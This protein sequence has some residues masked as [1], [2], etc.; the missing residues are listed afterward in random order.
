MFSRQVFFKFSNREGE[1][2]V[3]R[4]RQVEWSHGSCLGRADQTAARQAEWAVECLSS[5]RVQSAQW[6]ATHHVRGPLGQGV[7]TLTLLNKPQIGNKEWGCQKCVLASCKDTMAN[8]DV[9]CHFCSVVLSSQA[10]ILNCNYWAIWFVLGDGL[11]RRMLNVPA[12]ASICD[13]LCVLKRK[14]SFSFHAVAN[15]IPAAS[16]RQVLPSVEPNRI[17][18]AKSWTWKEA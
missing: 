16:W 2:E 17:N 8:R 9:W 13:R 14:L 5:C 1:G 7:S 4:G 12:V 11:I 18:W 3:A 6:K 10:A 15:M